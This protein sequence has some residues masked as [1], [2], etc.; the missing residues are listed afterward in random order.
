MNQ[1]AALL[2]ASSVDQ[3]ASLPGGGNYWNNL[4]ARSSFVPVL[5]GAVTVFY[6]FWFSLL[7]FHCAWDV[8]HM[9][10]RYSVFILEK[11]FPCALCVAA[12]CAPAGKFPEGDN[13]LW[14]RC[15]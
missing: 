15:C 14:P 1:K 5:A 9:L 4:F 11:P 2:R 8:L 7:Q 12:P 10:H 3:A 13:A 6:I